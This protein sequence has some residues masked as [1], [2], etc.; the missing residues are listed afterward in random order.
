MFCY[1]PY[2]KTGGLQE[3][4]KQLR[5]QM[6]LMQHPK[7]TTYYVRQQTPIFYFEILSL[8]G[9]TVATFHHKNK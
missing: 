6:N 5:N 7:N 2:G 8:N 1:S 3:L 9:L 4:S